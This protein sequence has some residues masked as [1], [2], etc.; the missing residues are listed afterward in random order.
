MTRSRALVAAL[1]LVLVSYGVGRGCGTDRTGE[2]PIS[3]QPTAERQWTCAMHPHIHA[4]EP[5]RC[6]I[7]GMD[8]VP[9]EMQGENS[10]AGLEMSDEAMK[11]AE[12]QTVLVERR[13]V[14]FELRLAGKIELDETR[15]REIT[16]WVPGRTASAF[17]VIF[18]V[19]ATG[20]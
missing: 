17:A 19:G 13:Q 16:A 2:P 6:P 10:G 7:C 20:I 3:E 1:M 14:H 12:I 18:R 11:R 15:V 4:D 5:G 9:V 8:L